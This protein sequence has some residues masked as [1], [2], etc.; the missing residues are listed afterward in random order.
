MSH[1]IETMA[2]ANET[3]WHGLGARVDANTSVDEMLVAAGLDWT[4]EKRRVF[5]ELGDGTM[6]RMPIQRALVRSSDNKIMDL[7]GDIW[8]PLQ[9]R[10]T[11]E[12]FRE[13]TEAGG[14]RLE[15]AGSLQGG[16]TIW[17]L[18]S[19]NAGF[20]IKSTDH[21]KGYILLVSPH[22]VGKCISVR[23]TTVRVVCANTLALAERKNPEA[24]RQSHMTAFDVNR[25]REAIGLAREQVE[26]AALDAKA[27]SQLAMSEF[28]TVRYLATFFQPSPDAEKEEEHVKSLLDVPEA[29]NKQM[30]SIFGAIKNAPGAEEGTAW[31]VLNGV[32]YWADH[33]SGYKAESRLA[34][35]WIGKNGKLKEKVYAGLLEMA[36]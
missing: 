26:Q 13:Y 29:M 4:I 21:V 27:L 24:Y 3:P 28:D 25:A 33:L 36:D 12:F 18:A 8:K 22:Q 19:I 30:Q 7:C 11:M 23:T 16:K 20:T 35:A 1:E 2:Y 5:V 9:N 10:D 31:G 34:S 6:K 32:T 17:A 14:A 15:T